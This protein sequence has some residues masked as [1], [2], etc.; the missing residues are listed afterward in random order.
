LQ[1]EYVEKVQ[2]AENFIGLDGILAMQVRLD[3]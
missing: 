3:F 2:Q 1:V